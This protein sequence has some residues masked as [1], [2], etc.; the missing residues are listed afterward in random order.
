MWSTATTTTTH[1]RALSIDK[2]AVLDADGVTVEEGDM[3][4]LHTGFAQ[5]L[6]DAG[7]EPDARGLMMSTPALDGRDPLLQAWITER[8]SHHLG[9]QHRRRGTARHTRDDTV[10]RTTPARTVPVQTRRA[11]R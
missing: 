6:L 10:R 7:D 4:C 11:P 9:R 8:S 5:L 2:M 1:V 3:L